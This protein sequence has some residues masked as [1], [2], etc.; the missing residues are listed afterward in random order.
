MRVKL[1]ENLGRSAAAR[2]RAAGHEVAT[3]VDEGLAGCTDAALFEGCIAEQ[4]VL[5]TS[6][7]GSRIPS[8]S[9]RPR[10]RG[11]LC[12]GYICRDDASCPPL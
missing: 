8:T 10:A 2:C 7:S 1:D 4:R 3:V 5:I 6:T 11:S 12:S 9:T